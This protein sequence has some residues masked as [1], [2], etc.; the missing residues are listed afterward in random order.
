MSRHIYRYEVP[1]DDQAH[2]FEG[3]IGTP[4]A[5]ANVGLKKVEFWAEQ[6]D[7]VDAKRSFRV[8]GTGQW[9]PPG[10]RYCG[11]APRNEAGLVWHLVELTDDV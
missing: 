6:A 1:A 4:V 8:Y 10:A 5:V 9:L 2:S 11:T 7:T 3:I